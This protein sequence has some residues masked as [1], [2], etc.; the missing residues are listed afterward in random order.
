[1]KKHP[2]LL[3]ILLF[4]ICS[5]CTVQPGKTS[6]QNF[7][8]VNDTQLSNLRRDD[9]RITSNVETSKSFTKIWF[10]FL[11]F[12][13]GKSEEFR[14]EQAY[15]KACKDHRIDGIVQ[16]KFVTR[17]TVVPL[18]L[19]SYAGYTTS[20]TGKGYLIKTDSQK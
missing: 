2:I 7:N 18:I 6:N 4:Y 10:L 20:V 3:V 13:G 15:L 19:I 12:G 11:P 1:M 5:A 14:R 17:R 8:S 16:P 9:Y